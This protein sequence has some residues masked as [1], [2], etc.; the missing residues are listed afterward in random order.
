VDKEYLGISLPLRMILGHVV[1]SNVAEQLER[2]SIR[3]GDW[4]SL[5]GGVE[6]IFLLYLTLKEIYQVRAIC[7]SFWKCVYCRTF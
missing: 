7:K 5:P 3:S 1:G 2:L 4:S 6:D